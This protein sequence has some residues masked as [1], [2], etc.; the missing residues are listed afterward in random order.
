MNAVAE[1]YGYANPWYVNPGNIFYKTNN[2]APHALITD[3]YG[4]ECLGVN[5][6]YINN[7]NYGAAGHLL[8]HIY[9][10]LNP[11]SSSGSDRFDPGVRP[12]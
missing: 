10:R 8:E 5:D 3:G 1:Y 4:G 11:P 6:D 7:C 9:G 12:R 2:R